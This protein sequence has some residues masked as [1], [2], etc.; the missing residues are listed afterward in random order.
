MSKKINLN[1]LGL[2]YRAGFV[3]IGQNN[4]IKQI[5]KQK[6]EVVII[7]KEISESTKRNLFAKCENNHVEIIE[8]SNEE[9]SLAKSLGKNKVQAIAITDENF[10]E[11]IFKERKK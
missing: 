6:L 10:S 2:A 5:K 11:L 3:V 1:T 4:I 9:D 8:I 7:D